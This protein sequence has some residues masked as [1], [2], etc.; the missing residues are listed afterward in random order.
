MSAAEIEESNREEPVEEPSFNLRNRVL[1]ASCGVTA[2]RRHGV[3]PLGWTEFVA[4]HGRQSALCP[5]CLRSNL[6]QIEAR[7]D[8]DPEP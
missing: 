2:P 5:S 1:C 7:L 4:E 3:A 6:W 8:F